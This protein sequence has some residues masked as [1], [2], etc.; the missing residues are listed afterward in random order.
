MGIHEG[1]T[2]D[3]DSYVRGFADAGPSD[4]NMLGRFCKLDYFTRVWIIQEVAVA[5]KVKIVRGK[6]EIA[7]DAFGTAVV[8]LIR[9][10]YLCFLRSYSDLSGLENIAFIWQQ[11]RK[12]KRGERRS[13]LLRLLHETRH[14]QASNARDKILALLGLADEGIE[15]PE[16][17]ADKIEV[18]Y[19]KSREEVYRNVT[20]L[21]IDRN[22]TL[23]TLAFIQH[24]SL[25]AVTK[26]GAISWVPRWHLSIRSF[27]AAYPRSS[28][29]PEHYS[30]KSHGNT[31]VTLGQGSNNNR[32]RPRGVA[33]SNVSMCSKVMWFEGE[34]STKRNAIREFW[35]A[36]HCHYGT[37][38]TYAH[39]GESLGDAFVLTC[40]AGTHEEIAAKDWGS[41]SSFCRGFKNSYQL[42]D[43]PLLSLPF[44]E[45]R[46]W[47]IP[48]SDVRD[49]CRGRRLFLTETGHLGLGPA[50]LQREDP[51]V[52]FLGGEV[53]FILRK[54][55]HEEAFQ[56]V[57]YCY[58]H[59]LMDG[60]TSQRLELRST[61]KNFELC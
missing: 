38:K 40:M 27:K 50:G 60:E 1:Q 56:L 45:S 11:H 46:H 31:T 43:G 8:C 34:H 16:R 36:L 23:E 33:I 58:V 26:S 37:S 17:D 15:N 39:T 51:V 25:R 2:S 61:E 59:G 30:Y 53:P 4:W 35:K 54:M 20:R 9:K 52:V 57:G 42:G 7:W 47:I 28:M 48:G 18:D 10:G 22:Q 5:K 14:Y 29:R 13:S 55:A 49:A 44:S 6:F 41:F 21:L 12:N 3:Q 24:T 19:S 32:I